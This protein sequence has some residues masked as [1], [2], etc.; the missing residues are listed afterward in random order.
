MSLF[1]KL[2]TNDLKYMNEYGSFKWLSDFFT[3]LENG[4]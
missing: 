1:G 2:D 4:K 3:I